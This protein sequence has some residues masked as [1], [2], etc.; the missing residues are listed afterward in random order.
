MKSKARAVQHILLHQVFKM[1]RDEM[2]AIR[3][4]LDSINLTE[5]LF[6]NGS[7]IPVVFPLTTDISY[8][9]KDVQ[10]RIEVKQTSLTAHEI[11][12]VEWFRHYI[13][14]LPQYGE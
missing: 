5:F 12:V 8:T 2:D 11:Q 7:C 4:G 3:T 13:D 1:Q 9:T 6:M 10:E 14:E